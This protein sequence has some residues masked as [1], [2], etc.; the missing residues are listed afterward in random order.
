MIWKDSD[1]SVVDQTDYWNGSIK[2][3][4]GL[5]PGETLGGTRSFTAPTA[6]GTYYYAYFTDSDNFVAESDETNNWSVVIELTVVSEPMPDVAMGDP[7]QSAM[8]VDPDS[9]LISW[10]M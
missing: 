2:P 4:Y 1:D 9:G 7:A 5:M 3:L 10:S 6:V 8:T